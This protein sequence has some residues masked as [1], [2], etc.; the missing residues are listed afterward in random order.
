MCGIVA[1]T[2]LNNLE[3]VRRML[4]PTL[5]ASPVL[6]SKPLSRTCNRISHNCTFH[7]QEYE[8]P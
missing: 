6:S 8:R 7:D 4:D 1:T 5:I 3:Q 2:G